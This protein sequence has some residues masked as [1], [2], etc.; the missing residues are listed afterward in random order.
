VVDRVYRIVLSELASAHVEALEKRGRQADLAKVARFLTEISAD[1]RIGTGK[2]KQLRYRK[3]EVWSRKINEK[4]RL[5]Y[6]IFE[7]R[8]L[9]E[10]QRALGHYDD[11]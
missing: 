4:D 1:P 11:K 3:G 6:E 10:V 5:V 2:P 9:V 8:I 7:D